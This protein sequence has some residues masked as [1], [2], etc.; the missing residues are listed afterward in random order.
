MG[1]ERIEME[2]PD[3]M[4]PDDPTEGYWAFEAGAASVMAAL[5]VGVSPIGVSICMVLHTVCLIRACE[6]RSRR[7]LVNVRTDQVRRRL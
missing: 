5:P 1:D 6:E 7:P 4:E 3:A 2:S